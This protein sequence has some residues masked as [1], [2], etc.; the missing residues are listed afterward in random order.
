MP[1]GL[2]G[3][4]DRGIDLVKVG[5]ATG[6]NSDTHRQYGA[7]QQDILSFSPNP[8]FMVYSCPGSCR[9]SSQ[10]PSISLIQKNLGCLMRDMSPLHRRYCGQPVIFLNTAWSISS[11]TTFST[12]ERCHMPE[13]RKHSMS[14]LVTAR[15]SFQTDTLDPAHKQL[16]NDSP[17]IPANH[18]IATTSTLEHQ[19]LCSN[20]AQPVG[21]HTS[22]PLWHQTSDCA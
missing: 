3:G 7:T 12:N 2:M 5:K 8:L 21:C 18:S 11:Q 15:T 20:R 16:P 4:L 14:F 6:S 10:G 17:P 22:A 13:L 9:T 19:P 1:A